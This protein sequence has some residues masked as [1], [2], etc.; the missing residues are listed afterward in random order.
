MGRALEVSWGLA[1]QCGVK[2]ADIRFELNDG[3]DPYGR[4]NLL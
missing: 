4:S 2:G 3:L 1:V